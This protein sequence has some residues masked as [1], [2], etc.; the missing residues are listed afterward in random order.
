MATLS[1]GLTSV[2]PSD[3]VGNSLAIGVPSMVLFTVNPGYLLLVAG[4][5]AGLAYWLGRKN[6]KQLIL[7]AWIVW[8]R[9]YV[10]VIGPQW[11]SWEGFPTYQEC[12]QMRL[13]HVKVE[14]DKPSGQ[15]TMA[16][17]CYPDT[18]DPRTGP[19]KVDNPP[20]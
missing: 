1:F 16:F 7:I 8:S 20:K 15:S 11:D 2:V 13:V 18:F 9:T 5:G 4:G 3:L 17:Y 19:L 12:E 14:K 6:M 10:P